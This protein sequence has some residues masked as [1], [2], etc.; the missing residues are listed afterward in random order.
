MWVCYQL[1]VYSNAMPPKTCCFP[2]VVIL[3]IREKKKG[4]KRKIKER[5]RCE[6]TT[7]NNLKTNTENKTWVIK[8]S[9]LTGISEIQALTNSSV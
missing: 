3:C 7:K 4:K 6:V 1:P 5:M 2:E 8:K 9:M